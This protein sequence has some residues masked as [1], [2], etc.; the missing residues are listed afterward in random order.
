VSAC[1][2]CGRAVVHVRGSYAA[3]AGLMHRSKQQ[4]YTIL[5]NTSEQ[6]G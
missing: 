2:N 1:A 3:I 6:H 5:V 4:S